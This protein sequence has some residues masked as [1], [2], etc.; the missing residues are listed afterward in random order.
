SRN[1]DSPLFSSDTLRKMMYQH[2]SLKAVITLA[3][4]ILDNPTGYGRI[5]RNSNENI[6]GIAEEKCVSDEQKAIKEVNGGAYIFDSKWLFSNIHQIKQNATGEYNLTDMV[7]IAVEQNKT[8][9]SVGCDYKELLG[10]NTLS[11]LE[12]VENI[13]RS[14]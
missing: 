9:T 5:I 12:T 13:L 11:E 3:S 10:I 1:A 14:R 8:I 2:N 7:R 6:I 4:S